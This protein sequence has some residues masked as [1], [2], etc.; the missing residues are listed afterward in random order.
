MYEH[1][2]TNMNQCC[3]LLPFFDKGDIRGGI[4]ASIGSC[5]GGPRD[6]LLTENNDRNNA[7]QLKTRKKK[8]TYAVPTGQSKRGAL[9]DSLAN[10][11]HR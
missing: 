7:S 3:A 11:N 9:S 10:N 8:C 6:R 1:H 5:I 2:V 4:N